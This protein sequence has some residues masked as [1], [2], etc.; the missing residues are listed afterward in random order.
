MTDIE[1][2][3]GVPIPPRKPPA[4]KRYPFEKL[5]VGDS[6]AKPEDVTPNAMRSVAR[7]H[8][9]KNGAEYKVRQT[10]TGWRVWRVS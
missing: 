5:E 10:E 9:R 8:A 3:S 7:Y 4:N 6:F 2:D 1:I